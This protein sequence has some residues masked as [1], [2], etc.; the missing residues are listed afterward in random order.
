MQQQAVNIDEPVDSDKA[1]DIDEPQVVSREEYERVLGELAAARAEFAGKLRRQKVEHGIRELLQA[2]GAKNLQAVR[3]LLDVEELL[4][5]EELPEDWRENMQAKIEA[6]QEE[7]ATA[8][9]FA[10]KPGGMQ[11]W[12]GLAPAA[13][14]DE[15]DQSNEGGFRLRL[16]QARGEQD[17]LAAIRIKQ[18][19]AAKGLFL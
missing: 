17:S 11:G 3:G 14:G 6:L 2:A 1:V 19:A 7:P 15:E 12:I 4:E 8:F 13:A 9:L 18:E 16:A 10:Q 5:P